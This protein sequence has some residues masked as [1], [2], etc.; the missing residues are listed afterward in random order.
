MRA[1][2]GRA[3]LSSSFLPAPKEK[4]FEPSLLQARITLLTTTTSFCTT[5]NRNYYVYKVK[6]AK[7]RRAGRCI[8]LPCQPCAAAKAC[9]SDTQECRFIRF[10]S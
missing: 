1:A 7:D 3:L 6:G 10:T 9:S 5:L 8:K 4:G 2:Q